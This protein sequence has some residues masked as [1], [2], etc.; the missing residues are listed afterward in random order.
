MERP[1]CGK[2]SVEHRMT[3]PNVRIARQGASRDPPS[4]FVCGVLIGI[5][6]PRPPVI[7]TSDGGRRESR[8][9]NATDWRWRLSIHERSNG[10]L[11]VNAE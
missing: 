10:A 1:Q 9:R 3:H 4:R 11:V 2:R 6:V 8:R 7:V 5:Y